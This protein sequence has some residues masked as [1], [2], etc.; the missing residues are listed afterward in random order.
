M[1]LIWYGENNGANHQPLE[2]AACWLGAPAPAHCCR[3]ATEEQEQ[4]RTAHADRSHRLKLTAPHRGTG[5]VSK[6]RGSMPL[7][8]SLEYLILWVGY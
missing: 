3:A 6:P 4:P 1:V 5:A 8:G 7:P 2:A